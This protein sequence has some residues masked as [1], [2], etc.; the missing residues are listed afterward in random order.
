[1]KEWGGGAASTWSHVWLCSDVLR[2]SRSSTA[3][4]PHGASPRLVM[5]SLQMKPLWSSECRRQQPHPTCCSVAPESPV[6]SSLTAS[7]YQPPHNGAELS[8]QAGSGKRAGSM[9]MEILFTVFVDQTASSGGV[10]PWVLRGAE[11]LRLS[12]QDSCLTTPSAAVDVRRRGGDQHRISAS[13][14]EMVHLQDF[15]VTNKNDKKV[16]SWKTREDFRKREKDQIVCWARGDI[17]MC[18]EG[19]CPSKG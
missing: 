10:G 6:Q 5:Q 11:M 7:R 19:Q 1:M 18:E 2:C 8:E 15:H 4:P 9:E 12:V 17:S 16:L 3:P 14:V 13:C